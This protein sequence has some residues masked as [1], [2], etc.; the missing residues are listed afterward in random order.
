M[1]ISGAIFIE[2]VVV[3]NLTDYVWMGGNPYDDRELESAAH[4][5]KALS[6]GLQ[7][8]KTFY[9]NL[10]AASDHHPEIQRFFP[11]TRSYLRRVGKLIFD[12]SN[13]SA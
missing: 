3:Q 1:F 6:A 8:L 12:I 11:F 7:D 13:D 2:N 4:L 9:G 5:F 10:S